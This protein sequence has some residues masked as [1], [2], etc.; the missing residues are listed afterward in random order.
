MKYEKLFPRLSQEE[1]SAVRRDLQVMIESL[2]NGMRWNI[3]AIILT[4][5]LPSGYGD[6]STSDLDVLVITRIYDPLLDNRAKKVT[7]RVGSSCR[8]EVAQTPLFIFQRMPSVSK[9]DALK[10][11]KFVYGKRDLFESYSNFK[12]ARYEAIKYLFNIAVINLLAELQ[13]KHVC[14]ESGVPFSKRLFSQCNKAYLASCAALLI[15]KSAYRPGYRPREEYFS[16]IYEDWYPTL[17]SK[18][19]DLAEKVR[20]STQFKTGEGSFKPNNFGEFVEKSVEDVVEVMKYCL[21]DYFNTSEKE[22]LRLVLMLDRFPHNWLNSLYYFQKYFMKIG[23]PP[24]MRC[25]F[26]EPILNIYVAGACLLLA[27]KDR[28]PTDYLAIAGSRISD[29]YSPL[30]LNSDPWQKWETLKKVCAFLHPQTLIVPQMR[31]SW[32][33]LS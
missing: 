21:Q 30:K 29:L 14:T 13:R 28:N 7:A 1:E 11:G 2:C 26:L 32:D 24:P 8:F 23:R 20:L 5:S 25:L 10:A 18:I 22:T 9:Y 4:G 17:S 31:Y 3:C 27:V 16:S 12:I 33:P 19:P 15:L 6:L